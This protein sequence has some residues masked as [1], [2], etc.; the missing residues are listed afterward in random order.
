MMVNKKLTSFLLLF[1]CTILLLGGCNYSNSLSPDEYMNWV[2]DADNGLL[3][4]Q[5][6]GEYKFIFQ[7]YPAAYMTLKDLYTSGVEV[8]KDSFDSTL[9]E[10]DGLQYGIF[11][12]GTIS[13]NNEFLKQGVVSEQEYFDRIQYFISM[14][15][16]DIYLVSGLDTLPCKM[17]HFERTFSINSFDNIVLGFDADQKKVDKTVIF[18]DKV[19]GIGDIKF[20]IPN[21]VFTTIPQIEF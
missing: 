21:K 7:Y 5:I 9:R 16:N 10:Y 17:H 6:I 1:T 20:F 8:N 18:S 11:K 14:V 2:N 19:L 4:E 3:H 15:Q 13:G 12:I